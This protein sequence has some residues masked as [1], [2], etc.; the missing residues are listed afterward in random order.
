M[1]GKFGRCAAFYQF[2]RRSPSLS[3]E[4]WCYS[5]LL[6]SKRCRRN[7]VERSFVLIVTCRSWMSNSTSTPGWTWLA[8]T[9]APNS[10]MWKKISFNASSRSINPK[11]SFIVEMTPRERLF[12]GT[13][14]GCA[15]ALLLTLGWSTKAT[16]RAKNWFVRRSWPTLNVTWWTEES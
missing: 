10:L 11:L 16:C 3:A 15:G 1:V 14:E 5:P 9:F 8:A 4:W 2:H 6:C 13:V 12:V 7:F